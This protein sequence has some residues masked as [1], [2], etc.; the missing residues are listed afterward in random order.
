MTRDS[1]N[2]RTSSQSKPKQ[3]MGLFKGSLR[4]L[5]LERT[6]TSTSS[7]RRYKPPSPSEPGPGSQWV[8]WGFY[9]GYIGMIRFSD[10]FG[11]SG[12]GFGISVRIRRLDLKDSAARVATLRNEFG[13]HR[14]TGPKICFEDELCIM[15]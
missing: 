4:S 6:G 3:R 9:R 1:Y 14:G 13:Q 7:R 15:F 10:V 12:L 8:I 5:C 2:M 11:A